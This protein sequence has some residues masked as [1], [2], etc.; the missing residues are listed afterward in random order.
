MAAIPDH[1]VVTDQMVR[2]LEA[3]CKI[4]R[5]KVHVGE[6]EDYTRADIVLTEW[7]IRHE[8]GKKE[9]Q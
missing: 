7:I 2:N 8:H 1:I 5:A 3:E 6:Y 4:C 9:T